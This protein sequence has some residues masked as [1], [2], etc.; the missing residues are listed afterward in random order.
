MKKSVAL[1]FGGEGCE[2]EI[3][4]LGAKN[5][6]EMI[7]REKF[8]VLPVYIS[9][10][11]DWYALRE[12][13]TGEIPRD[14]PTFPVRIDGRSGFLVKG[15]VGTVSVAL[16]ILHGERGEDGVIQGTLEAAH[17]PYIGCDVT[18]G[19]LTSDKAY[20]KAVAVSLGIPTAKW[21]TP[22]GL[23]SDRARAMAEGALGY[24]MFIKPA[25][26]GSSIGISRVDRAED[27]KSA[28]T[29]ASLHGRVIIEECIPVAYEVE[30]GFLSL[31]GRVRVCPTG[32]VA[33][34]GNFYDY[35]AKYS[36]ANSPKTSHG[37]PLSPER[38]RIA[39]M[40][41]RLVGGL[42]LRHFARLDFFVSTDG[43]IYFN[44]INSI[45]GMTDTSLFPAITEDMGLTGG[46]FIN[47]LIDEV[48][49]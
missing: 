31:D 37:A 23:S 32:T 18:A 14:I 41:E 9:E 7:D 12:M 36:G 40:A 3:S 39:E 16:P 48:A 10:N 26:R 25:R 21:I 11:G 24:P 35:G 30:C 42:D 15:R 44:E 6:Y 1:I 22:N 47:R 19:A 8:S 17:I 4:L 33:T 38:E 43:Q 27:F 46:E 29:E 5:I 2:R 34:E 13:P 45:P 49:P 28:Y 20:T